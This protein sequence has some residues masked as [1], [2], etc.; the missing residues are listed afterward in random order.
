MSDTPTSAVPKY[1]QVADALLT[2]IE[3]GKYE[4]GARMPSEVE[5]RDVL[6]VSLG[7]VQKAL[8]LLARNG[9]IIRRHGAGTFVTGSTT[10]GSA[11]RTRSVDLRHFRFLADDGK[12]VLPVYSKVVKIEQVVADG[13]WSSFLGFHA[14]FVRLTRLLR[15]GGEFDVFSEMYF[16]TNQVRALLDTRPDDLNGVL[17]RDYVHQKFRLATT[18]IEQTVRAGLLPSRACR[19][20]GI[21]GGTVGLIWHILARGLREEPTIFQQVYVPPTD[22]EL[23]FDAS[24]AGS[25]TS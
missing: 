12:T 3:K 25:G 7:T 11:A 15:I 5:L 20:I 21:L 18:T 13:D 9:V 14:D 8:N 1:R 24:D 2:E 22:R 6:G 10:I 4:P 16:V 17:I 19:Q 23:R